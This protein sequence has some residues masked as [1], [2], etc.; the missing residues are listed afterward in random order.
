MQTESVVLP[1]GVDEGTTGAEIG[2]VD[3]NFLVTA[4]QHEIR[5]TLSEELNLLAPEI[6]ERHF[7]NHVAQLAAGLVTS[8]NHAHHQS[9][10]L[11]SSK[12]VQVDLSAQKI[13]L[14]D[15]ATHYE[16][17]S[18]PT[19]K[20]G[21]PTP[22]TVVPPDQ[23]YAP[24][25][26]H[27]EP[28][29]ARG[30]DRLYNPLSSAES[31]RSLEQTSGLSSQT[32]R[33]NLAFDDVEARSRSPE[34][35]RRSDYPQQEAEQASAHGVGNVDSSQ[36]WLIP[37]QPLLRGVDVSPLAVFEQVCSAYSNSLESVEMAGGTGGA[38][39]FPV[40]SCQLGGQR[41]QMGSPSS[42]QEPSHSIVHAPDGI[43]SR[44]TLNNESSIRH[45]SFVEGD[46]RHS[47]SNFARRAPPRSS[48]PVRHSPDTTLQTD[49]LRPT[50]SG[51]LEGVDH[52]N[53]K[54]LGRRRQLLVDE[55]GSSTGR[56]G[57]SNL[58]GAEEAEGRAEF[59][60]RC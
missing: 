49:S 22:P 6:L 40:A 59:G 19:R 16:T 58:S 11:I 35:E 34:Q 28:P 57:E 25:A 29:K 9:N 36:Q 44:G 15:A 54:L 27:G 48:P 47:S 51:P 60:K 37:N 31:S 23:S 14:G 7:E 32:V 38:A 56:N 13:L 21:G 55:W 8:C 50:F 5:T 41:L 20:E 39:N 17:I 33:R 24:G 46:E 30:A 10:A 45:V 4:F 18:D 2:V 52:G 43:F 42:L 26:P 12:G 1:C 3:E 53:V